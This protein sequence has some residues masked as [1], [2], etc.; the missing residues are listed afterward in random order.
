[1]T[2]LETIYSS[3]YKKGFYATLAERGAWFSVSYFIALVCITA[4]VVAVFYTVLAAGS[5]VAWS[6][7]VADSIREYFPADAGVSVVAGKLSISPASRVEVRVSPSLREFFD[8]IGANSLQNLA[9]FDANTS[10]SA[11]RAL[12]V[13]SSSTLFVGPSERS[14]SEYPLI[15]VPDFSLD[16]A[17]ALMLADRLGTFRRF[18]PLFLLLAT[19]FLV[20]FVCGAYGVFLLGIA[21][22]V[23]LIALLLKRKADSQDGTVSFSLFTHDLPWKVR[24][25]ALVHASTFGILFLPF[26]LFVYP[27]FVPLYVLV[28][29]PVSV[30]LVLWKL[31]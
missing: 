1:M 4:V 31:K 14:V 26:V 7:G 30:A 19:F 2:F 25:Q 28:G 3:I 23:A 8:D 17:S 16:H 13:F 10:F 29:L 22:F 9:V 11:E 18:I 24:Y 5:F 15:D 21:A 6:R 27:P 12:L 20:V